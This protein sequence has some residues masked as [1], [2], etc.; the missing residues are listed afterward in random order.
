MGEE[1][2]DRVKVSRMGK[3]K[4]ESKRK[5]KRGKKDTVPLIICSYN[6]SRAR[7]D[8]PPQTHPSFGVKEGE[9][10]VVRKKCR[11]SC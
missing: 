1:G 3:K 9:R 4:G 5:W 11:P 10:D 7:S 2:N 8:K 6:P